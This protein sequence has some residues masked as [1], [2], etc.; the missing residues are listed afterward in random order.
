MEA[1]VSDVEDKSATKDMALIRITGFSD[2][3][4]FCNVSALLEIQCA[5]KAAK[6]NS[7]E[8][9]SLPRIDF[10]RGK[11]RRKIAYAIMPLISVI[12]L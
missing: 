2:C 3:I 8:S 6:H 12:V 10:T 9:H 11:E 7:S 4:S 1:E 5:I